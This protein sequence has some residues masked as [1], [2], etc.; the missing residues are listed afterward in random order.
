MTREEITELQPGRTMRKLLATRVMGWKLFEPANPI[1]DRPVLYWFNPNT[2]EA[3]RIDQWR[4]DNDLVSA[5]QVLDHLNLTDYSIEKVGDH[6]CVNLMIDSACAETL[7]LAISR[8]ALLTT[9]E[10]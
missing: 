6:F 3:F 4:P 9:L 7:P 8:A 10:D 5:F 1:D 2:K